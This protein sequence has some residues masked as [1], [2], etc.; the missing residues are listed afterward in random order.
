LEILLENIE[1]CVSVLQSGKQSRIIFLTSLAI[2]ES[3]GKKVLKLQLDG[4]TNIASQSPELMETVDECSIKYSDEKA[5]DP[6]YC[7]AM[8]VGQL[9]L[10]IHTK[11]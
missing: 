2:W 11:N 5:I 1:F 4:L 10:A 6:I 9:S 8:H 7:L 3:L